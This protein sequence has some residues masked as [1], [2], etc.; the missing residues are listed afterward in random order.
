M[1]REHLLAA[2]AVGLAGGLLLSPVIVS[3]S[4]AKAAERESP[5]IK[6]DEFVF[7]KNTYRVE[8]IAGHA[9]GTYT[10]GLELR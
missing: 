10:Y 2:L 6:G 4:S 7:G 3:V 1:S 8:K 9:D 5:L